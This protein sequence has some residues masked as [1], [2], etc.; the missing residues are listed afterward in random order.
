MAASV[1]E[2][3]KDYLDS[4]NI[5]GPPSGPRSLAPGALHV[6]LASKCSMKNYEVENV[7]QMYTHYLK[8]K[9]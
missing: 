2:P 1:T 9:F 3:L 6:K 4:I 7:I 8:V 5:E